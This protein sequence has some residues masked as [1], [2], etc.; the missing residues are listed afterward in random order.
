MLHAVRFFSARLFSALCISFAVRNARLLCEI[1]VYS[2][3]SQFKEMLAIQ[4]RPAM[5]G[6]TSEQRSMEGA[7]ERF[8]TQCISPAFPKRTAG[9]HFTVISHSRRA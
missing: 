9:E 3:P 8:R 4:K 6:R 2:E 5:D 1:T 7:C